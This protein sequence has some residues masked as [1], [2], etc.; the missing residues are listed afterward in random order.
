ML[1]WFLLLAPI[2]LLGQMTKIER[3]LQNVTLYDQARI[4]LQLETESS[5]ILQ[6]NPEETQL[7]PYY[8][9]LRLQSSLVNPVG[10]NPQPGG[11]LKSIAYHG[12][13]SLRR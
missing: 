7:I 12:T 11:L 3:P 5:L 9:I 13:T 10:G 8:P 2:A 4:N 6:P 1:N